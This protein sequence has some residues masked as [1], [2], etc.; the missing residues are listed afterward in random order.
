MD[1]TRSPRLQDPSAI[2]FPV[3]VPST[4]QVSQK[5]DQEIPRLQAQ[6]VAAG[7]HADGKANTAMIVG[8][9]GIVFGLVG[10]GVAVSARRSKTGS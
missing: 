7:N 5:L 10:I 9:L 2:Q 6:I 4:L 8:I 1:R 3:K